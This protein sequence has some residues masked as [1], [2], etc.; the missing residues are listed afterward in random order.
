MDALTNLEKSFCSDKLW[1]PALTWNTSEPK[2]TQCLSSIGFTILPNLFFWFLVPL[3]IVH[4]VRSKNHKIKVNLYN[5]LRLLLCA[6]GLLLNGYQLIE[7]FRSIVFADRT[8]YVL[9]DFIGVTCK[10]LTFFILFIIFIFHRSKGVI[11]SGVI[12]TYLS[13]NTFCTLILLLD[14]YLYN[15]ARYQRIE[16]YVIIINFLI[17]AFLFI[18]CSF[19]DDAYQAGL[20]TKEIKVDGE[21]EKKRKANRL[22]REVFEEN[23]ADVKPSPE[24]WQS[25]PSSIFFSWFTR[26]VWVGRHGNLTTDNLWNLE[27][28]LKLKNILS[29]FGVTYN[30]E[31]EKFKLKTKNIKKPWFSSLRLLK[32]F[33]KHYGLAFLAGSLAKFAQDMFQFLNPLLLELL[34][35]YVKDHENRIIWHGIVICLFMLLVGVLKSIMI[36]LYFERMMKIGMKLRSNII[37]QVY[38]KS[39]RLSSVSKKDRSTGEIVNLISVDANRFLDALTFLNLVWSAPMQII[40][41]IYLLYNQLGYSIFAG[42]AC[43]IAVI[44][45]NA[46]LINKQ[47]K[48]QF[49]QMKYK[50]ER[51]KQMNEI[52]AGVKILKLYSWEAKFM[53]KVGNIRKTETNYIKKNYLLN[54][55]SILFFTS[56]GMLVSLA[57]F[58]VYIFSS[59]DNILTPEKAFVSITLFSILQ[60]PINMLPMLFNFLILASVAL[61]RINLFLNAEELVDY[62]TRDHDEENAVNVEGKMTFCWEPE[63]DADEEKTKGNKKKDLEKKNVKTNGH[64]DGE[65][66]NGISN[67]E[68]KKDDDV[69]KGNFEL[70][71]LEFKIKKGTFTCII[72]QVGSGK[73][74]LL[75]ALLG[76]MQLREDKMSGKGKMNISKDQIIS[77]GPQ[78]AWIQNDTLRGNILF[79]HELDQAKYDEV[80]RCCALEPDI[81]VLPGKD[82]VEIGEKGINL[83]GGQKQRVNLARVCYASTQ[84]NAKP[85]QQLVLLDDPLSAVDSHTGKHL[86]ENVLSS[87]TGLLKD[88]TRILVTNQLTVL[89]S[90]SVDQILVMKD[91][92][93]ELSLTYDELMEKEEQGELAK[94]GITLKQTESSS[95]AESESEKEDEKDATK[96]HLKEKKKSVDVGKLVSADRKLI[97]N[98]KLET[99]DVKMTDYIIYIKNAGYF[100]VLL[101]VLLYITE[102]SLTL[103]ANVFLSSWTSTKFDEAQLQDKDAIY[104]FNKKQL[105]NY[106][107]LGGLQCLANLAGNIFLILGAI[108]TS[109]KFHKQLLSGI[110]RSPMSFFDTTP[111]GRIINRFSRDI[112]VIDSMIPHTARTF[113]SCMFRVIA[114]IAIISWTIPKILIPFAFVLVIYYFIQK[115]YVTTSRQLKRLESITRSPIYSHF[116]ETITGTSTIRAFDAC[117][118]FTEQSNAQIHLSNTCYWLSI[119]GYRW[120]GLRLDFLGNVVVFLTS[121]FVVFDRENLDAGQVGLIVS[122]AMNMTVLLTW[123]VRMISE[124]ETNVVS[125]ERLN[126]YSNNVAEDDWV[127]DYRPPADWPQKG[128]VDFHDYS[129]KYREGTSLVL[130]NL[131]F[132]INS[133]DKIGV[134]GRTGAGKSS[135]TLALFRVIEPVEGQIIIDEIDITKIGLH[136]LRSK[137][138][139]IP[140]DPVLFSGSIRFNLDP[141]DKYTDQEIWKSLE[142]AHL[143]SFV[144]SLEEGLQYNITEGGENLSLG[145]RQLI[146]LARALLKKSKILVLD[147]ATAS[148]D[149]TTDEIIQKTIRS[150][151]KDCT[152][153]TIA[154]RLNTVFDS[155]KI[156]VLDKGMNVEYDTPDK[157]LNNPNSFFYSLAK[158]S[159]EI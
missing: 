63:I 32:V 98:E 6:F 152:T 15:E 105:G 77:Y 155:T 7:E 68:L 147:E 46:Y 150:E 126:E 51:I 74:S 131:S 30:K 143:K 115:L 8:P 47:K 44:P 139:I 107:L 99:K 100:I 55:F 3:E 102:H 25:F 72:G 133:T 110:L 91:G 132:K 52:L 27:E 83:S 17:N 120:L 154:H 93:I 141:F 94:L 34:I 9:S 159:N 84:Q 24:A 117:E 125:V 112:D 123:A 41:C 4:I 14:V 70:K 60:F 53:E 151:F 85:H 127:K 81:Q 65:K 37:N 23:T 58:S 137:L 114:A 12:W 130:K 119:I 26:V 13:F 16:F 5:F 71:D 36:N 138:S 20:R 108:S 135:I 149:Y 80:I 89:K 95:G 128:V 66:K 116:S 156:L 122:Y 97:D 124:L 113:V 11:T 86:I 101:C 146:C 39:L 129:T 48:I 118:R 35:S 103:G 59:K 43:I 33:I 28:D 76:E 134:V 10:F 67:G 145:Q 75:S 49:K 148:V 61:K 18:L 29:E 96:N 109:I 64:I 1:E 31:V 121:A 69:K 2:L 62:V 144:N 92:K 111:L 45:I 157:L 57:T 153:I 104:E 142:S 19:T 40:V 88:T 140:Q 38:M 87:K 79:G 50:D 42:L 82:M 54:L 73:S 56:T 90:G 106:A 158:S 78:L 21:E 136:D 22:D